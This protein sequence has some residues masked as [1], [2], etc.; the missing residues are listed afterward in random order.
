M[1]MSK[2]GDLTYFLVAYVEN[3]K[4]LFENYMLR[5]DKTKVLY[6]KFQK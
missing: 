5:K 1:Y 2:F 6:T 3:S 4:V